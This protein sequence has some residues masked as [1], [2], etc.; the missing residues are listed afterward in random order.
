M[1]VRCNRCHINAGA[2]NRCTLEGSRPQHPQ[3]RRGPHAAMHFDRQLGKKL[4]AG[5]GCRVVRL[6][7]GPHLFLHKE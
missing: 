6:L 1:A 2:A 4:Q 5:R 7:G 3:Q